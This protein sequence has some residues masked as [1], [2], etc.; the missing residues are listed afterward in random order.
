MA[1]NGGSGICGNRTLKTLE[2]C[3]QILNYG[4][5][6]WIT[7]EL[8]PNATYIYVPS[9]FVVCNVKMELHIGI[10]VT[11]MSTRQNLWESLNDTLNEL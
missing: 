8:E 7:D 11:D 2:H 5:M 4:Q 1:V 9:L 3:P 6:V 10:L